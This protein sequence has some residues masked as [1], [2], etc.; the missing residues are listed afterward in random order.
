MAKN[1]INSPPS[2]FIFGK[3]VAEAQKNKTK[4]MISV[5]KNGR[6]LEKTE[7]SSID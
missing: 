1:S 3:K 2:S 5:R 7:G 4:G 6:K